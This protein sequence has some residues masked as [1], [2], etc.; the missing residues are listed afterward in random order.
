MRAVCAAAFVAVL[1]GRA[2]A[3]GGVS[4]TPVPVV[5][6]GQS[7]IVIWDSVERVEHFVRNA[8]FKADG[9]VG[10]LAP[11]PTVPKIASVSTD[12]FD[13]LTKLCVPPQWTKN[14]GG[15][16]SQGGAAAEPPRAVTVVEMVDV[17]SYTAAVLQAGDAPALKAW[18][19]D[20]DF[21]CPDWLE[22]WAAPYLERR[23]TI[24][25]FKL[26]KDANR[27]TGPIR[28]T[29]GTDVP[30]APYAVPKE[31]GGSG[32]KL[33]LFLVSD[34]PLAGKVG[35]RPWS[36]A[37]LGRARLG[38]TLCASLAKDLGLRTYDLPPNPVVTAYDDP[39]FGLEPQHDL[40][41]VAT[42]R[43]GEPGLHPLAWIAAVSGLFTVAYVGVNSL[44]PQ[45]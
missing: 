42:G 22:A 14:R 37:G 28:M 1:T 12:A 18:L 17:G 11:T 43:G 40:V 3:C 30:F 19:K 16:G 2:L 9:D 10:F 38:P 4:S 5:F 44:R 13:K 8:R 36:G 21:P 32:S 39:K 26:K 31:N 29:F 34:V 27:A 6:D 45:P 15:F 41:F 23:W 20:N 25:A 33:R 35:D 24:T 7:D